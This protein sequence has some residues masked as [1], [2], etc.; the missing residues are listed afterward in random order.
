MDFPYSIKNYISGSE[1]FLFVIYILARTIV[2][3][4]IF[5]ICDRGLYFFV[6]TFFSSKIRSNFLSKASRELPSMPN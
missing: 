2:V 1:M 5:C 6:Q 3:Y 4:R